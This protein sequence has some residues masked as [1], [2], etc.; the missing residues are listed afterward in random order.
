MAVELVLAIAHGIHK[1][2]KDKFVCKVASWTP[3]L[4][5]NEARSIQAAREYS[6]I[7]H[8]GQVRKGSNEPYSTHPE[9]VVQLLKQYGYDDPITQIIAYLHDTKE[10]TPAE[11]EEIMNIWGF[12]VANGIFV[13]SKNTI[14]QFSIEMLAKRM[15]GATETELRDTAYKVRLLE[16]R[17][18]IRRIKLADNIDNTR[19]LESLSLEGQAKKLRDADSF[20]IPMGKDIAPQM[21]KELEMNII[22]FRNRM[23]HIA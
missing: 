5:M 3:T 17:I 8:A 11:I 1:L 21:V 2:T 10:D 22:N 23:S 14:S 13:L 20:Y 4:C 18:K 15:K 12:E 19:D 16:S 7:Q 6:I 9:A